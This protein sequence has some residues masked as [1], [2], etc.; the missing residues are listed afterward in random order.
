MGLIYL[1]YYYYY[2][3]CCDDDTNGRAMVQAAV[4]GLSMQSPGLDALLV[5]VGFV[6]EKVALAQVPPPQ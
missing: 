3:Y 2:Y 4:S 6:V 5:N 1:Y